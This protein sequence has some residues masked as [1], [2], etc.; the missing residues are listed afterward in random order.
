MKTDL[1][2]SCDHCWVFQ[3]CWTEW[4]H[5]GWRI[6]NGLSSGQNA[7]HW[8]RECI[9]RHTQIVFLLTGNTV[10]CKPM[11]WDFPSGSGGKEF[12][13][14][15]GDPGRSS[16]EGKDYPLWYC[17][18]ENSMDIGPVSKSWTSTLLD[19]PFIKV[20]TFQWINKERRSVERFSPKYC[21]SP[22]ANFMTM[23]I[24]SWL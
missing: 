19:Q 22:F 11:S 21:N 4:I 2:Q 18:L 10:P 5:C 14:N 9:G 17:C 24:I 6:Q 23:P 20:G 16:G 15:T 13:S 3:I 7:V 8:R 12:A 1:F